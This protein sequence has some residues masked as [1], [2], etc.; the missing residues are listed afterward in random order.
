MLSNVAAHNELKDHHDFSNYLV[1]MEM[2]S[3][4][5]SMNMLPT[6]D[7]PMRLRPLDSVTCALPLPPPPPSA[8]CAHARLRRMCQE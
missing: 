7:A 8:A 3:M 4:N 5:M 1:E 6:H 2:M